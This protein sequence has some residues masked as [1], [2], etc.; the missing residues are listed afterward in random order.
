MKFRRATR[1][2][3]TL[4]FVGTTIPAQPQRTEQQA[5]AWQTQKGWLKQ[6]TP[7][8]AQDIWQEG[9]AQKWSSDHRT[10]PQRGGYGGFCI[11]LDRL[12]V[13]FGNQHPF[14]LSTRP[15][16]RAG[17]PHF[18]FGG[19]SFLLVDPWPEYWA[20]NWY[21]VNDLYIDYD[22]GYYLH[23]QG[24]AQVRLAITVEL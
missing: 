21:E 4:L 15:V 8:P 5:R 2:A 14:R 16:M 11:P 6:G 1:A 18:E 3:A 7:W 19:Y 24:Y 10:W 20:D 22:D 13:A 12:K 23:N 17:Y 9:R